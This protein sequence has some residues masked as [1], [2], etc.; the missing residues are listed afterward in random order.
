MDTFLRWAAELGVSDSIDSSR[1]HD[2]CL[3]HSLSIADFPLAGGRGSGAVREL[4]KGELV[5]KVPRNALMTT[6][7][8]VAKDEKLRNGVNEN[9]MDSGRKLI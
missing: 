7:S 4:R 2:S 5:L 8:V 6:E 1:S 9:E 3:D